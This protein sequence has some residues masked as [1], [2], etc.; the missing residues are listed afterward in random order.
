V[1]SERGPQTGCPCQNDSPER[2][3]ADGSTRLVAIATRG[4][5]VAIAPE[6]AQR[7]GAA[8]AVV[9]RMARKDDPVYGINTGFGSFAEVKIAPEALATLQRISC[10]AMRLAS[11][12][13]CPSGTCGRYRAPR[14]RARQGLLRSGSRH[15]RR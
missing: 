8:R 4:E 14:E 3:I 10:G 6:A 9:E 13:L 11:A 2:L 5:T 1:T 7:V 12:R 15:W